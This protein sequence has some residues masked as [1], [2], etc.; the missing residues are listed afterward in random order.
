V[1][2]YIGNSLWCSRT[3]NKIEKYEF[4]LTGSGFDSRGMKFLTG[5]LMYYGVDAMLNIAS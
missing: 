2:R 1:S 3:L 5:D 4:D